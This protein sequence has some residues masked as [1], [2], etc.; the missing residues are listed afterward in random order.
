MTRLLKRIGEVRCFTISCAKPSTIALLPTPGS[1]MRIGLFFFLLPRISLTRIISF[2]LPTTGSS[3]PSAAACVRS[4]PKLSS[5]GVFDFV[6]GA[7]VV[8]ALL[9]PS[10]DEDDIISSSISSSSAIPIPFFGW[11]ARCCN[12]D[13]ALL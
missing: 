10:D 8:L 11:F 1:P 12:I 13:I 6:R 3:F 2:S 7:C 5:T 9:L 4:V